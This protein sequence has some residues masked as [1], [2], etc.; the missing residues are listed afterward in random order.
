MLSFFH[1]ERRVRQQARFPQ[2]CNQGD[3]ER[4]VQKEQRFCEL[5]TEFIYLGIVE[6]GGLFSPPES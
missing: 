5:Q 3:D 1:P 2:V 6:L 4:A